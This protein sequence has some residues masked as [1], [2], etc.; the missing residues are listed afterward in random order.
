MIVVDTSVAIALFKR[1]PDAPEFGRKIVDRDDL[2]MSAASL[3]EIGVVLL[4][5]KALS[6]AQVES[7][8]AEFV[9][10]ARITVVDVTAAQARIARQAFAF[11]GKRSGHPAQLNF[12][13]CF[14][15][16]L[17]KERGAPVLFKG[18]DFRHTDLAA[19]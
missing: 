11:Y 17:A 12:G 7:W 3:V 14:T 9:A 16:A 19:A 10:S 8:I 2:V 6:P 5:L 18:D 13:D 4:S 15:D 1:E